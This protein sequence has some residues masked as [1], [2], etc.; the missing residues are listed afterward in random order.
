MST[1]WK[2]TVPYPSML[3][4]DSP[5]GDFSCP[6]GVRANTQLQALT[7]MNDTVFMEAA[8]ALGLR[9]W[10]KGGADERSKMTYAFRLWVSRAPDQCE[11]QKLL[12]LF[13]HAE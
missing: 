13:A 8:Q 6:R 11:M 3:A 4:F 7:T 2:R 12:E 9:V 10:R 5:N 1:F